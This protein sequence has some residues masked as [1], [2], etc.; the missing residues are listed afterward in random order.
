M[1]DV[2]TDPPLAPPTRMAAPSR[3]RL[4]LPP[5]SCDAHFHVFGPGARFPY[6]AARKSTPADAPKEAMFAL[7]KLLGIDHGVIVH[8]AAHGMDNAVTAD[9]L[10]DTNGS[11]RGIA[12]VPIDVSDAKLMM[13]DAQGFRGARFHYMPH[14]GVATP[15]ADVM[16]FG[17]R[18][19]A[20]GWHLQIHMAA[21]L[22]SE[23]SP[24]LAASPVPVV[25][26]HIG[27]VDAAGGIA[28]PAFQHLLRLMDHG[29]VWMKV[30]GCDRSTS[31]GPP[32]ADAVPLAR[33][34]VADF[35]DRVVWGTDWPHP[36]HQGPIPDDGALVDLIADMAP[37][38]A[39]RQAL[40][41]DNPQRLYD[42]APVTG[43]KS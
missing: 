7:H 20:I 42:F 43:P 4:T 5:G 30:S 21:D 18:L 14:L 29:H 28:Q 41:V 22:I 17:K 3:P 32:Y 9:A 35:G 40:L 19:A 38:E 23:L 16:A 25:I 8:T 11:Y 26:D 6:A 24:A 13:L 37:T 33:K 10:A 31:L 15:I 39:S 12:L 27:R 36:N 2:I 34:L 1:T